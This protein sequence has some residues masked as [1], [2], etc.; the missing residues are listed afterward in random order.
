MKMLYVSFNFKTTALSLILM[1]AFFSSNAQ[2]A[3]MTGNDRD[4]HG[5]IGS[6]GYQWSALKNECIRL[7]ESGIRLDAKAKN[8]DKSFSTFVVF[9]SATEDNT[10][11]VFIPKIKNSIILKKAGKNDAGTWK[12][13][14]YTLTLRKGMYSLENSSKK[15]LYQGM[16][17]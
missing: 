7:F 2:Q 6:A 13:K 4:V 12:N 17:H 11:E 5:C 3:P 15:L 14:Q 8:L 1:F 9:K 10:V 16:S